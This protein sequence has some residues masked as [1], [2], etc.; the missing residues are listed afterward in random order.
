MCVMPAQ[1]EPL[2]L[3]TDRADAAC[4][5]L[6]DRPP[7]PPDP[8]EVREHPEARWSLQLSKSLSKTELP[9]NAR[10]PESSTT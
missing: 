8:W 6:Q 4:R 5:L 9:K 3:R 7:K 10:P 1:A 2:R